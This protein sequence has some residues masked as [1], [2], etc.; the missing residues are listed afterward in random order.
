M[1]IVAAHR[2]LIVDVS[3]LVSA[4]VK[5]PHIIYFNIRAFFTIIICEYIAQ[6]FF[7]FAHG[8]A[9]IFG[10]THFGI[11]FPIVIAFSRSFEFFSIGI[12]HY[13]RAVK[14][15]LN[16]ILACSVFRVVLWIFEPVK[17]C[18]SL[19]FTVRIEI[20]VHPNISAA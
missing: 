11:H 4:S 18:G 3:F 8:N 5:H 16:V 17:P 20:A 2:V 9:A 19:L 15:N 13:A 14:P 1:E 10:V 6:T 7:R 12:Q